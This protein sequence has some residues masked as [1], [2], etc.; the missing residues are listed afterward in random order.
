MIG[1]LAVTPEKH[2][3]AGLLPVFFGWPP[4]EYL[5]GWRSMLGKT[6][7]RAEPVVQSWR[8]IRVLTIV[9]ERT[10]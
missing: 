5:E 8:G 6:G 4:P 1:G 10:G 7:L 2:R 9:A 3:L